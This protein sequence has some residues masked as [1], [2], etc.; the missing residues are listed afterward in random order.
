MN[1]FEITLIGNDVFRTVSNVKALTIQEALTKASN[2]VSMFE[3]LTIETIVKV[4][5]K[6]LD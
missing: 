6:Y 3:K 1:T 5:V 2:L 4:E